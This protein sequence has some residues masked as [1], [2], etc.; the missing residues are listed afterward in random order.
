MIKQ[1]DELIER[2]A[3]FK[4]LFLVILLALPFNIIF[5]PWRNS[6]LIEL[7]GI[8]EP[9]PDARFNYSPSTLYTLFAA[10]GQS[11]RQL[12]A[13]SEVTIDLIYPILYTLLL[14]LLIR[15]TVIRAFPDSSVLKRLSLLPFV[16]LLSDYAENFS[17][18]VLSLRYPS[19]MDW[20]AQMASLFTSIKWTT[21][22]FI[23]GSILLGVVALVI[24]RTKSIYETMI[25]YSTS[26]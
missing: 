22:G 18:L 16:M 9:F 13:L 1:L 10:C 24:K 19:G 20:L 21:L 8:T 12:Y 23:V 2:W 3:D 5:F 26:K 7:A 25:W 14:S 4:T 11:G 6:K 15:L 17:L